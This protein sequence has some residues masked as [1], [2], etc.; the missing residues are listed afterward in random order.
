MDPKI[1]EKKVCLGLLLLDDCLDWP[2]E[3]N[4][5]SLILINIGR[6]AGISR[7]IAL[8]GGSI[9]LLGWPCTYWYFCPSFSISFE[10]I[11]VLPAEFQILLQRIHYSFKA[12]CPLRTERE[13]C[14][15]QIIVT[16]STLLLNH[17]TMNFTHICNLFILSITP[18]HSSP[19]PICLYCEPR[20]V[21]RVIKW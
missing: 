6:L 15:Y 11:R 3:I 18:T 20:C 4:I 7:W 13:G 1:P 14:F 17:S 19:R 9:A 16:E 10:G 2:H 8:R 12:P 21:C 5:E